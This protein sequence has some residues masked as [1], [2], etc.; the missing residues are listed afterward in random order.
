MGDISKMLSYAV[1]IM[2]INV[3]IPNIVVIL[4]FMSMIHF[5]LS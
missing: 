4:T 2:P 3:K 5:M 1:F